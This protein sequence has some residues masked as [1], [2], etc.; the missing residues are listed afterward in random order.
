MSELCPDGLEID[1]GTDAAKVWQGPSAFCLGKLQEQIF[2][3]RLCA[4]CDQRGLLPV[5]QSA[6]RSGRDTL[7]QVM[8][9]AQRAS[10]AMNR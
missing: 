7:E 2:A 8:L 6:F 1:L 4:W 9:L 10:Q 3:R 5:E